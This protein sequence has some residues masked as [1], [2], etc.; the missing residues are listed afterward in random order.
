[1]KHVN[2]IKIY[3]ALLLVIFALIIIH[4]PLTVFL[5]TQFPNFA[6]GIKAWKEIVMLVAA[7][8]A[9]ILLSQKHLWK[10]LLS[11]KIIQLAVAFIGVH[12]IS[13]LIWNGADQAI[14]GLMIDLRFVVYFGLVYVL[15]L[16]APHYRRNFVKVFVA[17]AFVVIGFALLQQILPR[18][19]LAHFGYSDTT[20]APYMTVDENDDFVRHN[21]TLRGPNP[22]GAY[23][24]MVACVCVA[25]LIG[26]KQ[27]RNWPIIGLAL[28]SVLVVYLSY[29][30]SAYLALGIGLT[31]IFA[32]FFGKKIKRWQW[33]TLAAV[34]VL[35]LGGLFAFRN[36]DFISNVVLHEDPGESSNLNSND[37][38]ISSLAEGMEKMFAQP[39]GAGIGSTGSASLLGDNGLIIENYYLY[40]AH[41]VG[42]LGLA[43]FIALFAAILKK[44]WYERKNPLALGVFASGV[45]LAFAALFLP[46]FAD[47][48][49]SI[50]WWGL[51][52]LAIINKKSSSK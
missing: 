41:E 38:H 40:V 34:G 12:L 26:M 6:Q 36:T 25:W 11:D 30:R 44:L 22:L 45:G 46:V 33:A 19:F 5:G 49:V 13:L 35:C 3:A 9:V 48:T 18:D 43:L 42:W 20:I 27:K 31:I 15:M 51:A 50:V 28:A 16:T 2:L 39:L 47:D 29:A 4:A 10:K 8:L 37:G 7:I 1:M 32:C 14:A 17:G 23:A 21:S 52:A 24:A